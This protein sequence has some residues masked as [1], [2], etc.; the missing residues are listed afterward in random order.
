MSEVWK[1][2]LSEKL[3]RGRDEYVQITFMKL[4]KKKPQLEKVQ[5]TEHFNSVGWL[6]TSEALW[7]NWFNWVW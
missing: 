3:G 5:E 2:C 7:F 6:C 4:S 1:G